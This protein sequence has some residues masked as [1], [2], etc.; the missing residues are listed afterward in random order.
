MH[1]VHRALACALLVVA[2]R[3]GAAGPPDATATAPPANGAGPQIPRT[4]SRG[5]HARRVVYACRERDVPVYADRP[6]GEL[7]LLRSLDVYTPAQDGRPPTTVAEPAKVAIRP[8]T[9]DGEA[10]QLQQTAEKCQRLQQALDEVDDRMR[11]GYPARQ[12]AQLWQRWREA[13][14]AVREAGC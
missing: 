3:S 5:T 10:R 4:A 8:A 14:S 2:M 12:A 13:R 7:A 9:R 11:A 1:V 6:C